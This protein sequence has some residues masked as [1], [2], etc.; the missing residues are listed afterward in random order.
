MSNKKTKDISQ[1]KVIEIVKEIKEKRTVINTTLSCQHKR[2][3][4]LA[5][6]RGRETR[7]NVNKNQRKTL[8]KEGDRERNKCE[9]ETERM[10][11]VY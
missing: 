3:G 10:K 9:C 11:D 4:F 5:N 8:E 6:N 1:K 7:W 2:E